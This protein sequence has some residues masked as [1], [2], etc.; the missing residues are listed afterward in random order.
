MTTADNSPLAIEQ[1]PLHVT[2]QM[3]K[4]LDYISEHG[5]V[6]T[7]IT[8]DVTSTHMR[9][10]YSAQLECTDL[11]L[12]K[13]VYLCCSHIRRNSNKRSILYMKIM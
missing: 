8:S 1:L 7:I 3:Q 4:I 12:N 13:S 2:Q 11:L 10:S 5:E 9:D 6:E